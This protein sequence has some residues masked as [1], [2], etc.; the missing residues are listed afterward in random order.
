MVQACRQCGSALG[1]N[2]AYCQACGTAATPSIPALIEGAAQMP[3]VASASKSDRNTH[4][5][6]GAIF[7]AI[8]IALSAMLVFRP[9]GFSAET[10]G[11][12]LGGLVIPGLIAYGI[13]GARKRRNWL[14]YSG[15]LLL[16]V[17]MLNRSGHTLGSMS[18]PQMMRQLSGVDPVDSNLIG[19][20]RETVRISRAI[21]GDL[22]QFRNSQSSARAGLDAIY[23]EFNAAN[24]FSSRASAERILETLAKK[25]QLDSALGTELDA[26]PGKMRSEVD[27]SELSAADRA[28]TANQLLE[29]YEN[30]KSRQA[31]IKMLDADSKWINSETDLYKYVE[32]NLDQ[33][34]VKNGKVRII[35]DDV[36]RGFNSRINTVNEQR[37]AFIAASQSYQE[38]VK[39]ER[40]TLGVSG[41]DLGFD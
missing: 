22:R 17:L 41:A 4:P 24:T 23:P 16:F 2:S 14:A 6:G 30:S 12:W 28:A 27:K 31:S 13:S 35:Q 19:D 26:I 8:V 37:E 36:L 33:I 10:F 32:Q 18:K 34:S 11:Y 21:F 20:Q 40:K 5:L 9:N 3:P 7:A 25:S 15:W 38:A 1:E 29:G 39:N